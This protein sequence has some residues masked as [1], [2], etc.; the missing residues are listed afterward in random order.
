MDVEDD[1]IYNDMIDVISKW[2]K[3]IPP[4][5]FG[6]LQRRLYIIKS[7]F[8]GETKY[9]SDSYSRYII[10]E[11]ILKT[12]T[13]AENCGFNRWWRENYPDDGELSNFQDTLFYACNVLLKD[14]FKQLTLLEKKISEILPGQ[15]EI[16]DKL[17]DIL[18]K[19]DD[20]GLKELL[21]SKKQQFEELLLKIQY[22][23]DSHEN[24]CSHR[25]IIDEAG[26]LLIGVKDLNEKIGDF[27]HKDNLADEILKILNK[28]DNFLIIYIE[29][30]GFSDGDTL[31]IEFPE[32]Q[33]TVPNK[34][35]AKDIGIIPTMR[36]ISL[37]PFISKENVGHFSPEPLRPLTTNILSADL[38]LQETNIPTVNQSCKEQT[39][40]KTIPEIQ[41]PKKS[42]LP[43]NYKSMKGTSGPLDAREIKNNAV[44]KP[45]P[46]RKV[47]PIKV[48]D[49]EKIFS[50][51]KGSEME[52]SYKR[53]AEV[54]VDNT[55]KNDLHE[56]HKEDK[57]DVK[58]QPEPHQINCISN[59]GSGES[60]G[61]SDVATSP[62]L[63][64]VFKNQE[65]PRLSEEMTMEEKLKILD[66]FTVDDL[67]T[68]DQGS[69]DGIEKVEQSANA[70]VFLDLG[71]IEGLPAELGMDEIR[72]ILKYLGESID[73]SGSLK[74]PISGKMGGREDKTE[75]SSKK[76]EIDQKQKKEALKKLSFFLNEK[77]TNTQKDSLN[78][79]ILEAKESKRD[80]TSVIEHILSEMPE[81]ESIRPGEKHSGK[82]G[83]PEKKKALSGK[84]S[85]NDDSFI[86]KGEEATNKVKIRRMIVHSLI[87]LVLF[88][89][90][91]L[92]MNIGVVA[93][94][95]GWIRNYFAG[96]KRAANPIMEQTPDSGKEIISPETHHQIEI[97]GKIRVSKELAPVS[98]SK[99]IYT[100]PHL[101]VI[102]Y[103]PE[104]HRQYEFSGKDLNVNETGEFKIFINIPKTDLNKSPGK[105][106]LTVLHE[107]FREFRTKP[108]DI[109]KD[110]VTAYIPEITLERKRIN[111]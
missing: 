26:I 9:T 101:L 100:F 36:K 66:Y 53:T 10:G 27:L 62:E 64:P 82:L 108:L 22:G 38:P 94:Q 61:S 91:F 44:P 59:A 35:N 79:S 40:I 63:T 55:Q 41:S 80:Y 58:L 19:I 76:E 8:A 54:S 39:E 67:T 2:K 106:S 92:L 69:G 24:I 103:I 25:D 77:L 51:N 46:E 89:T 20:P 73:D 11:F 6:L 5:K 28:I 109:K 15:K 65:T 98:D 3:R 34:K 70:D 105:I 18:W 42:P 90:F 56:S 102:C 7:L 13:I 72:K 31:K 68:E 16:C 75:E 43:I 96:G 12:L 17:G 78:A 60:Y 71:S 95:K 84:K 81:A 23:Y 74:Q 4:G 14:S 83:I 93:N 21:K 48:T 85:K 29:L 50:K 30:A 37:K 47:A 107:K 104:L 33:K 45:L 110:T 32:N 86:V 99:G 111:P 87:Y 88:L 57:F 49:L 52:I 1:I 97:I